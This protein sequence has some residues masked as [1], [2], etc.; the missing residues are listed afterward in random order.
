MPPD[1]LSVSEWANRHR[2]L[3]PL[4]SAEPGRWRTDRTPYLKAIM[5]SFS[6]PKVERITLMASTQVGKT[7]TILN[8]MAYA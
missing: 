1:D 4:T 5:D 6:D 8:M 3:H 7:E 2:I